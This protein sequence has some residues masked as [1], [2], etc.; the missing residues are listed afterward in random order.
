MPTGPD[1]HVWMWTPTCSGRRHVH[2]CHGVPER[3]VCGSLR[4]YASIN[5]GALWA[6]RWRCA[7]PLQ[8]LSSLTGPGCH[9]RGARSRH[10][11]QPPLSHG[12]GRGGGDQGC[13]VSRG[14]SLV[15]RLSSQGPDSTAPKLRLLRAAALCR[16]HAKPDLTGEPEVQAA[17]RQK[18]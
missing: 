4:A 15:F 16:P 7:L 18:G 1:I 9:H 8:G 2:A 17:A 13:W 6:S 11:E 12:Q 5:D 10:P 14:I 3:C